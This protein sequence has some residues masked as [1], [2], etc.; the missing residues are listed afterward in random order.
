M[1]DFGTQPLNLEQSR[2][3]RDTWN[4]SE[5]FVKYNTNWTISAFDKD[6]L[7]FPKR[8]IWVN[9]YCPWL[10]LAS[11]ILKWKKVLSKDNLVQVVLYLDLNLLEILSNSMYIK[12]YV[13]LIKLDQFILK[14]RFASNHTSIDSKNFKSLKENASSN[15]WWKIDKNFQRMIWV[16]PYCPGY[17]F[18]KNILNAGIACPFYENW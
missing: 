15:I 14:R 4:L 9:P 10:V 2:K 11:Y 17:S 1:Q 13:L 8:T 7:N 16:K 12:P 5:Y 6:W 18:S 3:V